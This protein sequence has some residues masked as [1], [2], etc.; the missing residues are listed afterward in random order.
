MKMT[1]LYR[2][3]RIYYDPPPIPYRGADWHFYHKDFDGP[4]DKRHG[5]C[6][7]EQACKDEIDYLIDDEPEVYG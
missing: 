3:Y 1:N 5:D 2:N 6:A 7:S 4:G